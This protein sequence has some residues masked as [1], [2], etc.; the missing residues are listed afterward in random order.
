MQASFGSFGFGGATLA[1]ATGT[2]DLQAEEKALME[3][4]VSRML[5]SRRR[6]VTV[7]SCMRSV[8]MHSEMV[9]TAAFAEE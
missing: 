8:R 5:S 1:P 6:A 4:G 9:T 3:M 7:I 2:M